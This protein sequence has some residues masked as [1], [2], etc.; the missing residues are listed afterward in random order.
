MV[1][2]STSRPPV[3]RLEYGYP[4]FS[5]VDFGRGTLP[6]KVGK[7]GTTGEPRFALGAVSI[8]ALEAEVKISNSHQSKNHQRG[9]SE[10]M[11][12]WKTTLNRQLDQTNKRKKG[13][14]KSEI[15]PPKNAAQRGGGQAKQTVFGNRNRT[16]H[17]NVNRGNLAPKPKNRAI[18]SKVKSNRA[19]IVCG[20]SFPAGVCMWSGAFSTSTR[21]EN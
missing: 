21:P 3:E 14:A 7:Q 20:S 16:R 10:N 12:L 11:A 6:Q 15:S 18:H 19:H 1:P 5:V 4:I 13:G 17:A 9:F 8:Y 2:L